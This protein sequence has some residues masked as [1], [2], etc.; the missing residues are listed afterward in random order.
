MLATPSITLCAALSGRRGGRLPPSLLAV[1]YGDTSGMSVGLIFGWIVSGRWWPWP[2][3]QSRS[4]SS[5]TTAPA[6][7]PQFVA[8]LAA[9]PAVLAVALSWSRYAP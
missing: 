9:A 1:T 7:L 6:A 8:L 4:A 3:A 2:S 5:S